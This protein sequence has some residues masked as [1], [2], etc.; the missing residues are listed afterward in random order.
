MDFTT[1]EQFTKSGAKLSN[2]LIS[3][4]RALGFGFN[5]GFYNANNISSFKYVILFYS[6]VDKTIGFLFTNNEEIK[7]K[8][9][10]T[11]SENKISKEKTSGGVVARS[12]FSNYHLDRI[13]DEVAGKY[14]PI[15]EIHP[16]Y[17]TVFLIKLDQKI[18]K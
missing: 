1:L 10:I 5:A 14:E 3:I 6:A 18:N 7:G 2:N 17:G 15:K 12:F 8:F 16:Q 9:I 11:H 4:S 13:I